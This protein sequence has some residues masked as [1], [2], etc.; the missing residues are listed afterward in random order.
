M[1]Q[2]VELYQ[3]YENMMV[4]LYYKFRYG[5]AWRWYY[6]NFEVNREFL[7]SI[8]ICIH[9]RVCETFNQ[10]KDNPIESSLTLR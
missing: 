3:I 9:N 8:L 4:E 2:V 10:Q 6:L 1:I 5:H 7:P